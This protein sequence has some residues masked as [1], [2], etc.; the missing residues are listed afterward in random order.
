MLATLT[1]EPRLVNAYDGY[2]PRPAHRPE[3]RFERRGLDAGR[4]VFDLV[5]HRR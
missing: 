3:T 5:F 1:A 2:A 4:T